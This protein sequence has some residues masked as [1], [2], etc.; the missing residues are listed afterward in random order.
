VHANIILAN[1]SFDKALLSVAE[2][3]RTNGIGVSNVK[4]IL[5]MLLKN[6]LR[7]VIGYAEER[8]ASFVSA[9]LAL[10]VFILIF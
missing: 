8:C 5:C 7:R 10:I 1:S 9:P 3:L 4:I 6:H 2:G